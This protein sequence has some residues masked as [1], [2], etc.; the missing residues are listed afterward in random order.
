MRCGPSGTISGSK[1]VGTVAG[2]PLTVD[3]NDNGVVEQNLTLNLGPGAA[4]GRFFGNGARLV[5]GNWEALYETTSGAST[6][7]TGEAVGYFE[8]QR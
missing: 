6:V 5:S 2:G 3:F 4:D 1:F 7:S 8:A